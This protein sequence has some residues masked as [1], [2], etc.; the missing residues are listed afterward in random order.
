MGLLNRAVSVAP[1]KGLL[2]KSLEVEN[3]APLVTQEELNALIS[4]RKRYVPIFKKQEPPIAPDVPRTWSEA[5]LTPP[6]PR[7]PLIDETEF[8]RSNG[9]P[10]GAQDCVE[11][12]ISE[13]FALPLGV[14]FP[15][16]IFGVLKERL[17]ISKG[18]LL[19]YDPARRVYAPWAACGYDTTTLHRLRIPLP[20]DQSFPSLANGRPM[21]ASGQKELSLYGE[22]FSNRELAL[23]S[24]LVVAPFNGDERLFAILLVTS[25]SPSIASDDALLTGLER[26]AGASSPSIRKAREEK[27]AGIP[28]PPELPAGSLSER[29]AALLSSP[30]LGKKRL[31]LFS[32][33]LLRYEERIL[34]SIPDLDPFRLDEDVRC[35]LESFTADLGPTI[36]LGRGT[37]LI[38]AQ[39]LH[40]EN[41]GIFLHQLRLFLWGLFGEREGET[42]GP[43]VFDKT[44]LFPDDGENIAEIASFFSS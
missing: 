30:T 16:R 18:A 25:A 24:K 23:A 42:L 27:F 3:G 20:V 17:A 4:Q 31:L 21:I 7:G 6:T 40:K 8:A 13:I 19:L 1:G 15:A 33:S 34:S 43:G 5:G 9:V 2:Q 14:E 10:S 11:R 35:F 28:R 26:I 12:I 22:L 37:Y 41:L 29:I 32:L 36:P 38:A 39:D 44:R